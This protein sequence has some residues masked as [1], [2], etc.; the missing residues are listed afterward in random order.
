MIKAAPLPFTLGRAG[1]SQTV[2]LPVADEVSS[3]SNPP[4]RAEV[5]VGLDGLP[6]DVLEFTLNG[7]VLEPEELNAVKDLARVECRLDIPPDQGILGFPPRKRLDMDFNGLRLQV[8]VARLTRGDNQ[9]RLRLKQ[10]RPGADRPVRVRRI[11]LSIGYG[12]G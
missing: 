10:R 11:E 3:T 4:S 1:A 12:A 8:P 5:L 9:L 6:G 7:R 2:T